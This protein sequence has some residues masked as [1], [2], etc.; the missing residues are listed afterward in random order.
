MKIT[1]KITGIK[2]EPLLGELLP[3]YDF[4]QFDINDAA[5]ACIVRD[6]K[7]TFALSKWVSPK[8]TRTY[9]FGR[10][11]NTLSHSKKVT[12]IPVVKDEGK[13]GD[14]DYVQWDT[15]SLM[16]L[17]DVF[18]IFAYYDT[19]EVNPR[20]K[21]KIT[22][23]RFNSQFVNAKIKEIEQYHSSALHWN[24]NELKTNF[25]HILDRATSAY[26]KIEKQTG[27]QLHSQEG[28]ER[29][30]DKIGKD[31]ANFMEFSR[32]KSEQAQKRELVTIQP[33][34]SL[35]SQTKATIT[36]RNYLGGAY[37]LTVDEIKSVGKEI[38]LVESKHSK[39]ALLPNIGDI[40]DG[41]L[42]MILFSNL[43]CV[44]ANDVAV[45]NT[46]MLVLTSP[47]IKGRILSNDCAESCD[48]FL[49][50]NKFSTA[51]RGLVQA[52]FDEANR[53]NFTVEI[54]SSQ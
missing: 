2:Y 54:S 31:V 26:Q 48:T 41:L 23:Q 46:A 19:A 5:T 49:D 11:Y 39:K 21:Q 9:P 13:R 20:N 30:K 45:K 32:Q 25:H 12:V 36:I 6:G 29:F 51:Q 24:L 44:T 3:E 15:V 10:V 34:E 35:Q 18:V 17:L 22:R 37:F 53:N 28:L 40:K 50:H 43:T 27:V 8:R 52:L 1:G 14:R 4:D 42:K 16:S 33:K 38:I 7:Y 47:H